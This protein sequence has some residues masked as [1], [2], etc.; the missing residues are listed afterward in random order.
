MLS[1]YR[2]EIKCGHVTLD[3]SPC[4]REPEEFTDDCTMAA[5]L[6]CSS[7]REAPGLIFGKT[8]GLALEACS[9]GNT[10]DVSSDHKLDATI[11]LPSGR[12]I[13]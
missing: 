11:A 7:G 13:I 2:P 10:D 4:Q 5:G 8:A 9:N 12:R 1:H 6:W 3:V